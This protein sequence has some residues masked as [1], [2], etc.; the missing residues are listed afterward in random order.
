MPTVKDC[1]AA[2]VAKLYMDRWYTPSC[3]QVSNQ[4]QRGWVQWISIHSDVRDINLAY[5]SHRSLSQL[6]CGSGLSVGD[7]LDW[8]RIRT[9][10]DTLCPDVLCK[11]LERH[12]LDYARG[13]NSV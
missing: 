12:G 3:F 11:L 1:K 13:G 2:V 9:L 7:T 4:V 8:T 6:E 5:M 10:D